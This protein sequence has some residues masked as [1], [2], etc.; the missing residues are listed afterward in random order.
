M[1]DLE[2]KNYLESDKDYTKLSIVSNPLDVNN[3]LFT[4]KLLDTLLR[5]YKNEFTYF[6]HI[7]RS[8]RKVIKNKEGIYLVAFRILNKEK[9]SLAYNYIYYNDL[10]YLTLIVYFLTRNYFIAE[11][12]NEWGKYLVVLDNIFLNYYNVDKYLYLHTKDKSRN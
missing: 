5:S 8:H 1:F 9:K 12:N 4:S 6:K 10:L 7:S 3:C 2:I 11:N